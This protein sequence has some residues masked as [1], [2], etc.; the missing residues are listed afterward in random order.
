MIC[1]D[2]KVLVISIL[3]AMNIMLPPT[4][5]GIYKTQSDWLSEDEESSKS[6]HLCLTVVV[7]VAVVVVDD[8]LELELDETYPD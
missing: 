5:V 2:Y 1:L 3:V 8:L 7:R 4:S 6:L